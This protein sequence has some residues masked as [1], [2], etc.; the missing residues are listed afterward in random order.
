MA[1]F[2][3]IFSD[4]GML[5]AAAGGFEAGGNVVT[6]IGQM[7]YG[8]SAREQGDFQAAQLRE[9]AGDSQASGQ[10]QAYFEARHARYVASAALA[11]AA[12]S[13]GGASDPTVIN[14]IAEIA[15]EGAYR[16]KAALY[17]GDERARQMRMQADARQQEG[18]QRQQSSSLLAGTSLMAAGSSLLRTAAKDTM[19]SRYGGEGPPTGRRYVNGFD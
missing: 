16:E 11:S 12:A 2:W 13:G 6:A 5:N 15:Q 10:R 9:Q 4:P 7:A 1:G 17:Q 19:L 14:I 3:D 18:E 8:Q